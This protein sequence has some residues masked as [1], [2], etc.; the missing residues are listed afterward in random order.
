M[1]SDSVFSFFKVDVPALFPG[2]EN[3]TGVEQRVCSNETLKAYIDNLK[4][5]PKE[6]LKHGTKGKCVVEYTVLVN[7]SMKDIV[8]TRDIGDGCG[9]E[10]MRI[11]KKMQDD[12]IQWT[13]ATK[14]DQA[15]NVRMKTVVH[16]YPGH[17]GVF[18]PIKSEKKEEA[19]SFRSIR[20]DR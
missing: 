16:F 4:E 2:C 17:K 18:T 10:S 11:F 5:F 15:V 3:L 1:E 8:L 20:T 14:G 6:A 13:P 19:K 7:G 9:E 12:R